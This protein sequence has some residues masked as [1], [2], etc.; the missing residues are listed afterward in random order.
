MIFI[1]LDP[2]AISSQRQMKTN[3]NNVEVVG[4]AGRYMID[5]TKDWD[6]P[7]NE[8]NIGDNDI[9]LAADEF[10]EPTRFNKI[11][12]TI[13]IL[14]ILIMGCIPFTIIMMSIQSLNIYATF[15]WLLYSIICIA[16]Y[17]FVI[18]PVQILLMS[19]SFLSKNKYWNML[20]K[21]IITEEW[22]LI[23]IK[24]TMSSNFTFSAQSTKCNRKRENG[25]PKE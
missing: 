16:M 15:I 12:L 2:N 6:V 1:F 11:K 13:G 7:E 3:R 8:Y 5:V 20:Q 19:W 18:Q 4:V 25:D 9:I 21:L 14:L 22:T 23:I 10:E 24:R 17:M